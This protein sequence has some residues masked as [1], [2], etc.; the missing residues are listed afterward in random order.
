MMSNRWRSLLSRYGVA[1]LA[2][3]LATVLRMWLDPYLEDRAPFSTYFVAIMFTAWYGGI[4]PA[5]FCMVVGAL[6]ADYCFIEPRFSFYFQ[7]WIG[8]GIENV[9]ALALY[10]MVGIAIAVLS[11]SLLAGQRRTE[12]ARA[13]LAKVNGELEAEIAER[14]QA[15]QWLLESEQRFRA[16][17]EQGLVG[18]VLLSPDK[19]WIEVNPRFCRMI[20]YQEQELFGKT[21]GELTHPDD[22]SVEEAK[23]KQMLESHARSFVMKKR[24]VRRDGN[25]V[26]TTLSMECVR[27][28][29]GEIDCILAV[30]Q[31]NKS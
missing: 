8:Y 26:D 21:W 11:E 4:G 10:L 2:I 22:L 23:F 12:V 14:K 17:F 31:D 19:E 28:D 18:M 16:F 5:I 15:E 29:N 24:F 9:A 3:V 6:A 7:D 20:G 13:Q 25:T 1:F 30:V 27:K